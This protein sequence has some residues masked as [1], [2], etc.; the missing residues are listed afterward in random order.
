MMRVAFVFLLACVVLAFGSSASANTGKR[1]ALV[2]GMS[3]YQFISALDNPKN[4]A[5]LI[6]DTLRIVS[7]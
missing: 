3:R 1:V 6:A 7:R 5:R 2:V 4:D